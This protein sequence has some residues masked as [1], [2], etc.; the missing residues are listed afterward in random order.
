MTE[1]ARETG[2]TERQG[3][4]SQ[5][6]GQMGDRETRVTDREREAEWG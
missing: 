2:M 3:T 5:G 6:M 4:E 1:G